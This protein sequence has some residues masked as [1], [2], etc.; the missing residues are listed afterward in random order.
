MSERWHLSK[1]ISLSHIATTATMIILMVM[2]IASIEKDVAVLKSQQLNTVKKFD[3]IEGK[4]DRI[5]ILIHE[6]K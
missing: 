5:L 1:A 2:Y 6:S 3:S 4:L